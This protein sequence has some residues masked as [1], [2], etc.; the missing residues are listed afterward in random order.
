MYV[1]LRKFEWENLTFKHRCS[2]L[3]PHYAPCLCTCQHYR[4]PFQVYLKLL[5]CRLLFSDSASL[6][7]SDYDNG[8][9]TS[10]MHK[11][12]NNA[13]PY[14]GIC[15]T[16]KSPSKGHFGTNHSVLCRE[17]VLFSEV[18]KCIIT[19]GIADITKCPL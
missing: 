4:C 13:Q 2:Y 14:F 7:V 19:M 17:D 10:H 9:C 8:A 1:S 5:P 11:V 6:V 3:T 12:K 16:V 15:F 18:S